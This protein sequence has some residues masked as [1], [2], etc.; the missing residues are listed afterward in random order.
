MTPEQ[1]SAINQSSREGSIRYYQM[2][3]TEERTERAKKAVSAV[4]T[5]TCPHCNLSGKKGNMLRWHFDNCK[6]ML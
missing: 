1:R 3:T 5:L 6:N 2:L 4:P